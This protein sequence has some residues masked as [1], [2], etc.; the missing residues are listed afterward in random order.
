TSA[1]AVEH[2]GQRFIVHAAPTQRTAQPGAAAPSL[3]ACAPVLVNCAGAWAAPFA[4]QWGE[5]VP[6][7]TIPPAMGVTEPLPFF[8][9]WSLGVEGGSIYLRQV[10]RGNV[11]FGGGRGHLF[12]GP[13]AAAPE[14]AC[15]PPG[16]RPE[17]AR[18][19]HSALLA[20]MA[21]LSALL[22]QLAHAQLIRTWSGN[23]GCL[24]DD[25]P[26]LGPSLRRPGL[27][28]AFGFCGAGFQL[29]PGVGEALAELIAQGRSSTP[30]QAFAIDRFCTSAAAQPR[31]NHEGDTP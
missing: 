18:T 28:H 7:H 4:A 12:P 19:T 23:E 13:D 8:L 21:R 11:V 2:D 3:R 20:Q 15:G 30:L 25:Q 14:P 17:H 5:E 27:Y 9:P 16:Q 1:C 31:T 22:P 26:I 29:G 24:P 6:M 10:R